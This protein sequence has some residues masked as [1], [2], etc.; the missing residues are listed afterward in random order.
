MDKVPIELSPYDALQILTFLEE[1]K[2]DMKHRHFDSLKESIQNYSDE[3]YTKIRIDQ[4][5]DAKAERAVNQL[6]NKEPV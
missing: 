1:L 2:P 3:V 5:D 4:V 6:L